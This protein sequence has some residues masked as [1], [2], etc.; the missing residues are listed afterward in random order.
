[1]GINGYDHVRVNKEH[2]F[3][4]IPYKVISIIPPSSIQIFVI[5]KILLR[6]F[7]S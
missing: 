3:L 6:P 1:M 4:K 2:K 7:I 5:K